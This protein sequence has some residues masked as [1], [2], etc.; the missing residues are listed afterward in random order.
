MPDRVYSWRALPI[1]QLH[2]AA[3]LDIT[4]SAA[5]LVLS[6]L[7]NF[8]AGLFAT[9][10]IS[11]SV[12]DILLDNL[13]VVNV[14]IVF[15]EGSLLL[16]LFVCLL[17]LQRPERIP[18]VFK[19][20]ALFVLVRSAFIVMTHIGPFPER[21]ALD[22]SEVLR[23]FTF[24]GDLFFSGHTGSPF[25]LALIFWKTP[26]LRAIFLGA[27]GVFAIS[28]LLGHLHYS[29][30]VFAAF[31]ISYGIYDLAKF[32]FPREHALFEKAGT[33]AALDPA[34]APVVTI[35]NFPTAT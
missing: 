16:W 13:P 20:M 8:Y 4:Q 10:N 17:L 33:C 5:Y 23:V 11:N 32:L 26:K 27:S 7:V 12:T 28:V 15:I 18:F 22:P 3:V 9:R 6:F 1:L 30:D 14:D 19:S 24:G 31:F 21:S 29:I 35:R 25:L 2:K 34:R